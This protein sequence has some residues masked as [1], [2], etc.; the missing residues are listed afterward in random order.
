MIEAR[1]PHRRMMA[2][3]RRLLACLLAGILL[4]SG[5]FGILEEDSVNEPPKT[6]DD[7]DDG[8]NPIVDNTTDGGNDSDGEPLFSYSMGNDFHLLAASAAIDVGPEVGVEF[9]VDGCSR[10]GS[11]D[12]GAYEWTNQC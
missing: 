5:C 6:S 4:A 1:Q 8:N 10:N 9:D 12:I 11:P 3:A 7:P 2:T